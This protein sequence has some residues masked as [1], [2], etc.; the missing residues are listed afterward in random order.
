MITPNEA[1]EIIVFDVYKHGQPTQVSI[2][3]YINGTAYRWF[4]QAVRGARQ[5]RNI[6]I[7]RGVYT[8]AETDKIF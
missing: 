3:A 4:A 6:A 7:A 8:G 1:I 2:D 5:M